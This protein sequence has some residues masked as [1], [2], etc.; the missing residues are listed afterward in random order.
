MQLPLPFAS[1]TC[2]DCPRA[3]W[4]SDRE[5]FRHTYGCWLINGRLVQVGLC[6][7]R[8]ETV[9]ETDECRKEVEK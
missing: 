8:G 1:R 9:L 4:E 7:E 2:R 6:R 5:G 3:E